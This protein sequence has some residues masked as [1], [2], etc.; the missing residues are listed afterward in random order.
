MRGD[1]LFPPNACRGERCGVWGRTAPSSLVRCFSF[2]E[3]FLFF[4]PGEFLYLLGNLLSASAPA[5]DRRLHYDIFGS[6]R[7][8]STLN[9]QIEF[10]F[11]HSEALSRVRRSKVLLAGSPDRQ[12]VFLQESQLSLIFCTRLS[13]SARARPVAMRQR[14]SA[15]RRASATRAFLRAAAEALRFSSSGPPL[16]DRPILAAES[17]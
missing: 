8:T 10:F 14:S 17:G 9:L 5:G 7:G 12:K 2:G 16:A 6:G 3:R 11:E 15:R 13:S 4:L 1:W